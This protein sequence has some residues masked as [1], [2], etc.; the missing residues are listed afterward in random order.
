MKRPVLLDKLLSRATLKRTISNA[1]TVML[2]G[3]VCCPFARAAGKPRK[4][5]APPKIGKIFVV[6]PKTSNVLASGN[7][8]TVRYNVNDPDITSVKIRVTNG[9][10]AGS[11][12]ADLNEARVFLFQGTN[13][14]ELF[15]FAG[16]E[17]DTTA[18]ATIQVEC[19]SGCITGAVPAG[20]MVQ[21]AASEAAANMEAP[22]NVEAPVTRPVSVAPR[23]PRGS[24]GG[25]KSLALRLPAATVN[26]ATVEPMVIVQEQSGIR[27]LVIDVFQNGH[28]VDSADLSSIDYQDGLAI[29]TAKL[30]VADG[31]NEIH[32]FDPRHFGEQGFFTS[33]SL[34]CKGDKCAAAE[35]ADKT[36]STSTASAAKKDGAKENAAANA[37]DEKPPVKVVKPD[38]EITVDAGT[39]DVYLVAKKEI[40]KLK[41]EVLNGDNVFVSDAIDIQ[42]K[43]EKEFVV[44]AR[45]LKGSNSIAFFNADDPTERAT[46][47]VKCEGDHC[48]L[49]FNIA[50]FPSASQNSRVIVGF[51]QA[52]GSSAQ[53]ETKPVLDF[54]FMTPFIYDRKEDCDKLD[55]EKRPK[56]DERNRDRRILPRFGF[57]GDVRLAATPDQI[58]AAQV[59]PATLVNQ[60]DKARSVD[61]VQSFDFLAGGEFRLGTAN[62]SFLSLIPGVRQKSSLY[63][64]AGGGAISPLNARKESI[65]IF[66][67]PEATDA[68]RSE[69]V[70]RYGEP[71][72]DKKYIAISPVDRDR[73]LRQWYAGVRLKTFYCDDPECHRFKNNFPAIVDFM[74]G[75]NEA[76][77]G[78]SRKRGGTPDPNDPNKLIGQKN[79][80]ILRID[81]FYPFPIKEMSFLYFYG[82]AM[83]KIG[84]GGV[85]ITTPLFLDNPGTTV[86]IS[87][88]AV[89][90][91]PTSVLKL[92]QPDRDY[93]KLGVGINLT[94]LFN[95]NKGPH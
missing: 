81:G 92:Q 47:A 14:I 15:G 12:T 3:S 48:A 27:R 21:P 66:N 1:L 33:A 87:D 62:G 69:F 59:F 26:A 36:G 50:K 64:A 46:A 34:T 8:I 72:K 44:P 31:L 57:W 77:T 40:K 93:Y 32:V 13:T 56:C 28:R 29:V 58:A 18:R 37:D 85:K 24:G 79:S 61:L 53:S 75:Q 9:V 65:Q 45:I 91:P 70:N 83:M 4:Q 51:E 60:V 25:T 6:S 95:R 11:G 20:G 86:P 10:D 23:A 22:P 49:D 5:P 16:S 41:Y 76:V 39:V 19:N 90:M 73:F 78:G 67:I 68:R 17:L 42:D 35:T 30:K 74:F 89:F 43:D 38:K 80:Y 7:A 54:F 71:P 84:G 82:T 88:A 55:E 52:G 63:F 94:D 2:I